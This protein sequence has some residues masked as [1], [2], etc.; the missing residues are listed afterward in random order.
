MMICDSFA[1]NATTITHLTH[2]NPL[3]PIAE[4]EAEAEAENIVILKYYTYWYLKDYI[5]Y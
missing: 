5:R 4:A 1:T 3:R 2:L